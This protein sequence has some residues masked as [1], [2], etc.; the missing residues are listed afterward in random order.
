MAPRAVPA[1]RRPS[2]RLRAG[3]TIVTAALLLL[4]GLFAYWAT[5]HNRFL[6]DDYP[7]IE[8][9][10]PL[11]AGDWWTAAFGARHTPLANRPL[12]CLT[13]VLDIAVFGEGP[14]GPHLTNLLLHLGNALLL[15]VTLRLTLRAPNLGG[16]FDARRAHWLATFAAALWVVH[17]LGV[18]AVG[19]ATQRSTL[20]FSGCLLVALY[21]TVRAA[22]AA[23]RNAWRVLAVVAMA[24]GMASKEDMV[25]APLL[26]VLFERAFLLPSWAAL[27][28]RTGY[29]AAVAAS[30]LVLWLCVANGPRNSTIGYSTPSEI[31]AW[32]WLLT[33]AEVVLHYLRL[34][35]WPHPLRGAYD[36]GIVRDFGAA[37]LPG[38][39]VVA[40]LALAVLLWRRRPWWGWL[41][42]L[43]F[44]LL[45][46]TSSVM[47]ID[48]EIVAERRMYLPMLFVLLPIVVGLER[49]LLGA[50]SR[51]RAAV[52]VALCAGLVF[53]LAL[54]TRQRVAVYADETRFWAD[55]YQKMVPGRRTF[56]AAQILS[57]W[58]SML[59]QQGRTDEAHTLFEQALQ[60]DRPTTVEK[61]SYA[62][63]LQYRGRQAEALALLRE[64]ALR[65][66][67]NGDVLGSLGTC[68]VA[69]HFGDNGRPDD[70][71]LAEA[72]AALRKSVTLK[73][74]KAAY[75]TSLAYVW[76]QRGRLVDAED[77]Y[78]RATDLTTDH[79]EPYFFRAELLERLGRTSEV[80]PMFE[81]LA[82]ARP[83]DV[84]LRLRLA[85]IE[86]RD[87]ALEPAARWLREALRI[88]P[89]NARATAM[90]QQV[91][92]ARPR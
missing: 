27:R 49:W 25:A 9:N 80:A 26:L 22:D 64:L 58:G 50:A 37:A 88:E 29:Y 17:P 46:P 1:A 31:T 34:T 65:A 3:R 41:G 33:Q 85:E 79:V 82:A 60:C 24:L 44:L 11:L 4:V 87:R 14:F 10:L 23:A 13:F 2:P 21:A 19:Y 75:W 16:R 45:A 20:L 84:P 32:H 89:G 36:G 69:A 38:L 53:G 48:T 39:A 47:P 42:A 52:G 43:F 73:P 8:E 86:L 77:A 66:P 91:Q 62:V 55:A 35:L 90:L 83:T 70:P 72:E 78:R 67:E 15:F 56:L 81:R 51:G 54:V 6:F 74:R 28:T 61:M 7:A 30:W 5:W 12:T 18:D 57:N 63:S 59:W 71:R 68:L 40:L 92:A 76:K